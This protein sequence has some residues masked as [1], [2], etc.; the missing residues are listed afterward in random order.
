MIVMF[1]AFMCVLY[2]NLS[3]CQALGLCFFRFFCDVSPC[4]HRT[5]GVFPG[6]FLKNPHKN[7]ENPQTEKINHHAG[8][9]PTE[10]IQP[11]IG[12]VLHIASSHF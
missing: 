1:F 4:Q 8:H 5:Y 12:S 11:I 9:D 6:P 10:E 3:Q 2:H 7:A